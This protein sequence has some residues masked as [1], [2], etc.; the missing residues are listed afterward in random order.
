MGHLS[1][2]PRA[3]ATEK[4]LLRAIK[5]AKAAYEHG[6]AERRPVLR[7]VYL[8][9]LRALNAYIAGEPAPRV[10]EPASAFPAA[11]GSSTA[12]QEYRALMAVCGLA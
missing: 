7:E 12:D 9:T 6:T 5:A 1:Y 3:D 10:Y 11:D 4:A 2:S 8:H